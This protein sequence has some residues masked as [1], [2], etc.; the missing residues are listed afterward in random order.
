MIKTYRAQMNVSSNGSNRTH[1]LEVQLEGTE[2][3]K[4]NANTSGPAAVA[5]AK[6]FFPTAEKVNRVFLVELTK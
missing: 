5:Y 2:A 3:L 1:E 4:I 6:Q